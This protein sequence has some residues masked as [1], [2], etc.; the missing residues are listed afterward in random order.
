MPTRYSAGLA[1][2]RKPVL[3]EAA[4]VPYPHRSRLHH[5]IPQQSESIRIHGELLEEEEAEDA[6]VAAAGWM[7]PPASSR[8]A[9]VKIPETRCGAARV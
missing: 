4:S 1:A 2:A 9:V 7:A 6:M 3:K 8:A 5:V